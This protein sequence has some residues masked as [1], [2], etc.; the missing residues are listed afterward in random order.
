MV[1]ENPYGSFPAGHAIPNHE[2]RRDD[3]DGLRPQ[4]SGL[5]EDRPQED[6]LRPETSDLR[7][8]RLQELQASIL[9]TPANSALSC[10]VVPE[11]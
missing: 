10:F 2:H 3:E 5:R 6:G 11:A 8:D 7:E 9:R 1:Y 4:T